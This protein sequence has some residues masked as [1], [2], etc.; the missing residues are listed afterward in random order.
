MDICFMHRYTDFCF[1]SLCLS[2]RLLASLSRFFE[3]SS[4]NSPLR[5]KKSWSSVTSATWASIRRS[6]HL[7]CSFNCRRISETK[8]ITLMK[9]WFVYEPLKCW[10]QHYFKQ[11]STIIWNNPQLWNIHLWQ[12]IINFEKNWF[13]CRETIY[14]KRL[15]K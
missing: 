8:G 1:C 13:F 7:S 15:I 10:I 4:S 9:W 5:R 14:N 11:Q 3:Y 2:W 6:R 12:N